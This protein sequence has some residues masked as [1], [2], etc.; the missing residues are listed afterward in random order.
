MFLN[1]STFTN[2]NLIKIISLLFV[3]VA[4]LISCKKNEDKKSISIPPTP[5][6]LIKAESADVCAYI[7]TLGT[8]A[9]LH[10]VN[11][12]PQVSGQIT[13]IYFKQ[14]QNVKAGDVL[15]EI[16]SRPYEAQLMQAK[17][18]LTQAEAQLKIDSLDVE[19][20][21]KL[22]KD[23]Y[24][25]KQTFDSLVAKV[26]VDKGIVEASKGALKQAQ[27]NL[28]WCKIK[29]HTDG[30]VGLY[31]INAGN[32]VSA[33][34][35]VITTI[36]RV[37]RLYVDFVVASQRLFDIQTFMAKNGGKVN[38]EVSYLE[39]DMADRKISAEVRIVLNKI[40]YESSTAVLRGEFENPTALFWPNQP[41]RVKVNLNETKNAVLVPDMCIQVGVETPY[42]FVAKPYK[43][44]VYIV[45]QTNI[46]KGQ[47]YKNGMRLVKGIA[48]GD[49]VVGDVSN[50]RLQAGPFVYMAT[51]DGLIIENGKVITDPVK[52]QEFFAKTA[53]IADELR[54]DMMQKSIAVSEKLN[55]PKQAL[56]K[57]RETVGNP[58][59]QKK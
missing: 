55:A 31:N 37:D 19:R 43:D 49:L 21:R 7:D 27:I 30:K 1:L 17:G 58:E 46:E 10:S 35:S 48:A 26:E 13:K 20:N 14:G 6:T 36:E 24:V 51:P 12:V 54:A 29:A 53:K 59:S 45:S 40:R 2:M 38:I 34:T 32:V 52:M 39:G 22:A 8:I 25:D 16:D 23:N 47:L 44:G 42:V 33:G 50:L 3:S 4:F 5:A 11:V 18:N 56:I 41:V 28:D 15:A 57:A 9:S